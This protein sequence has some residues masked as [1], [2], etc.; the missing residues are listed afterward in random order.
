MFKNRI[1]SVILILC[2]LICI[3]PHSFATT[4]ISDGFLESFDGYTDD[5]YS[6]WETNNSDNAT[7]S[8]DG[9]KADA[10]KLSSMHSGNVYAEKNIAEPVTSSCFTAEF[11]VK[12]N[13]DAKFLLI[14]ADGKEYYIAD[15]SQSGEIRYSKT[16]G[17]RMSAISDK[18]ELSDISKRWNKMKITV[19]KNTGIYKFVTGN[20]VYEKEF[21]AQIGDIYGIKFLVG[22]GI[23]KYL[24]VDEISIYDGA[25]R[26]TS[27]GSEYSGGTAKSSGAV[28]ITEDMISGD[29]LSLAAA[30]KNESGNYKV[31]KD[32]G[33]VGIDMD[34]DVNISC[35]EHKNV[36]VDIVYEDSGYGWF[37]VKYKNTAGEDIMTDW[38]CLHNTG[39]R[40]T[41]TFKFS[42]AVFNVQTDAPDF[43][44][45]THTLSDNSYDR[46]AGYR[47]FSTT[48]INIFSVNIYQNGTYSPI[49]VQ[50]ESKNTGNIFFGEEVP[51]FN[52]S[53]ENL[54]TQSHNLEV[55]IK[56]S[57]YDRYMNLKTEDSM[58]QNVTVEAG[59]IKEILYSY[60]AEK[61]GL[62]CLDV[63]IKDSDGTISDV[64]NVSFS[65][66][67][68]NNTRNEAMGTN[69]HSVRVNDSDPDIVMEL[70]DKAGIGSLRDSVYWY[71]YEPQKDVYSLTEEQEALLDAAVKYDMDLLLV[72]LGNN[73]RAYSEYSLPELMTKEGAVK[74]GEFVYNLLKE[75]KVI[76]AA[77]R[78]EL[79][80]EPDIHTQ[81]IVPDADVDAANVTNKENYVYRAKLYSD[82]LMEGYKGLKK[83]ESETGKD[84]TAG[85]LSIQAVWFW[86][87]GKS[88][89]DCVFDFCQKSED[90][91]EFNNGQYFDTI[92]VH[93]YWGE[94]PEKGDE[95]VWY[96]NRLGGLA[97]TMEGFRGLAT[98]G[99]EFK[100]DGTDEWQP[101]VGQ[102]TGNTYNF[103][104]SEGLW[105]TEFGYSTAI[106]M[107]NESTGQKNTGTDEEPVYEIVKDRDWLQ[108]ELLI[109]G[110]DCIRTMNFDD[111]VWFYDF[112]NDGLRDNE[113]EENFG[114]LHNW[115]S[116]TPYAAKYGYLTM[117]AYNKLT[118]G[119]TDA[120]MY[121]DYEKYGNNEFL[122]RL[123]S[124]LV[125]I[126]K[127]EA[128]ERNV[129]MLR[130]TKSTE[131]YVNPS[132]IYSGFP[133]NTENLNFYDMLG[134]K[135]SKESVMS[136]G[137]Y[138]LTQTPFYV[139]EGKDIDM[140][141][142]EG[143]YVESGGTNF[144]NLKASYINIDE[145]KVNVCFGKDEPDTVK[146]IAALYLDG[147]M[148]DI[149]VL[150][151]NEASVNGSF[152]EFSDF[153]FLNTQKFDTVKIMAVDDFC[154][155]KPIL[156]SFESN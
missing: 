20:G 36:F 102:H 25:K 2:I 23:E 112:I 103:E 152:Y 99:L 26:I 68:K 136:N 50:V 119:A 61:Y 48:P 115:N 124:K 66:S 106:M 15:W 149:K 150:D 125:F 129:Y 73:G 6:L 134:N 138:I 79:W 8:E 130:T 121:D 76:E 116:A 4:K 33:R 40:I 64:K 74:Y 153:G 38:I 88:F 108:A 56:T 11:F 142:P 96:K 91:K 154:N 118:E 67:V 110:F 89:A 100:A 3:M 126:T 98:G 10:M 7:I 155:L 82:I 83:A 53:L 90:A 127:Y 51:E 145:L 37:C 94:D 13:A 59:E 30:T 63:S 43:E 28:F 147:R 87:A 57:A 137:K 135:I 9:Y 52:I 72:P 62:Y 71:D 132:D 21:T 34:A 107:N 104:L 42:D 111:K 81:K 78:I 101:A 70:A 27:A 17:N 133:K 75:P 49:D 117:A 140:S 113:R 80:N 144:K 16:G 141:E 105:H 14:D 97:E 24:Y 122:G 58:M 12:G 54:G 86:A 55:E 5:F 120:V 114:V 32:L 146:I 65:K 92:S 35:S 22:S 29:C 139:V 77:D 45:L 131:Q 46:A 31:L 39:E 84:Y 19:N 148:S 151:K 123:G 69:I 60:D 1:V 95:G 128:P 44:I 41:K 93:P 85:G 47:D 156:V 109:R 143:I 18:T